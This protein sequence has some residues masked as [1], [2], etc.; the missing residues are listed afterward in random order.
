LFVDANGNVG[1]GTGSPTNVGG[2]STLHL[3]GDDG[4]SIIDIG[5]T[6]TPTI[7]RIAA[8]QSTKEVFIRAANA[9]GYLSLQTGGTNERLRITSDGKLGLGT[10]SPEQ[11]LDVRATGVAAHI[12]NTNQYTQFGTFGV[13]A[14][15]RPFIRLTDGSGSWQSQIGGKAS[16]GTTTLTYFLSR[17][18]IGTTSPGAILDVG[19]ANNQ[20]DVDFRFFNRGAGSANSSVTL[21]LFPTNTATRGGKIVMFADNPGGGQFSM[22]FLTSTTT[23]EPSERMRIDTAG[24]LL[25]GTFTTVS[26]AGSSGFIQQHGNKSTCNL[27]LAGYANNLG[28]PIL[29]FGASRSTTV[30]TAGTIVNSGDILGD[31]RFAG[32]DGTDI[33][34]SGA[35]IR[36]EV[37]GTPGADD[38]PGRLVF[39]T[40]ADGAA[41]PTERLR[42]NS[43]GTTTLT[44]AA[45]TSPFIA[46]ISTAEVARIDSSG[47]LLLG[48]STVR[49]VGSAFAPQFQLES[50]NSGIAGLTVVTNRG[51]TLGPSISLAKSRGASVGSTTIVAD[52]DTLGELRFCGA[53]G[54]DI[55]TMGARIFAS[56]D[57]TP[58]AND[59]PGRLIFSTTADGA[60]TPTERLRIT[61]AGVLQVADAGHITVGT[62]T[63]TKIGTATTQ[64]LGF[65][66]ATPV[67]QP[68]AVA[69]ITTV[70]TA[71]TLPTADGSVTV[72][73][74]DDPTNAELLEY[75]VELEAKLEAAL[76][77]LRT[78]GLIA[79]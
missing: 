65:Y 10:S 31:I 2:Y 40:T 52:G 20:G 35:S 77:H 1:V 58:S 15:E 75:C 27:A 8:N 43:A 37:D 57:G 11:L 56:V 34:S 54:T 76:A 59:M 7:G 61:S 14:S 78:L 48:T 18:G 19:Q 71:G 12:G 72:A 50:P 42:I 26:I 17:V 49:N 28:G 73:D 33:N 46:K 36:A 22:R 6:S 32:D 16:D 38:M 62:T 79:T 39:S 3:V 25:V 30:G 64:K 9:S 23:A 74:A 51:D 68:A 63:G 24:R 45:A 55:E 69:D 21:G 66:N 5:S 4:G 67:V 47:R 13:G 70:A 53:D 41:S 60:A 29:A 44:S